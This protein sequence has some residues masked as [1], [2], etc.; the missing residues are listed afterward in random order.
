VAGCLETDSSE[1]QISHQSRS[2]LRIVK[3]S[4]V[5]EDIRQQTSSPPNC[6]LAQIL[7]YLAPV[8]ILYALGIVMPSTAECGSFARPEP[9]CILMVMLLERH[10]LRNKDNIHVEIDGYGEAVRAIFSVAQQFLESPW[11]HGI[12]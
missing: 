1:E 6:E 2:S 3:P 7:F 8:P 10:A 9:T 11:V 12:M 5:K 4:S